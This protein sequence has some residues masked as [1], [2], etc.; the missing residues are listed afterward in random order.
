VS[1]EQDSPQNTAKPHPAV[2]ALLAADVEAK[3]AR[4][5]DLRAAH[6]TGTMRLGDLGFA[7]AQPGRPPRPVLVP[8]RQLERRSTATRAGRGALIHALAHI[9]FNAIN[10]ALD[11]LCRFSGM[12]E[13]FYADWLG[14][15]AEEALH[16]ALL[17][18]HLH[19]LGYDYGDFSAHDGLWEMATK[20]AHDPL[21]RMAL[22]PRVLEARGLDASPGIINRLRAAGDTRGAQIVEII[23]RDEVG[24]VEIGSRWFAHLCVERGL[25][26]EATFEQLLLEHDAP[27]PVLPLNVEARRRALFS[28]VEIEHVERMAH[29]RRDRARNA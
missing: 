12:P 11:A 19:S 13:A 4:V 29:A 8:P 27:L 7:V 17:R 16:F 20:T 28:D 26:S 1:P 23:L 14:V 24:H 2:A 25:D 10:L 5:A 21:A 18:D 15:A 6:V 3:L 9:E 22:V